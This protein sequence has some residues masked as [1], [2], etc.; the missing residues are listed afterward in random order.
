MSFI[1][2]KQAEEFLDP[3]V[4]IPRYLVGRNSESKFLCENYKI[5]GIVDDRCSPGTLW[6]GTPI[7]KMADVSKDGV[8][9]NA[10]T[11][12]S[13]VAVD[14]ALKKLGLEK[15]LN[16]GHVLRSNNCPP[17]LV[18]WF[19]TDHKMEL[20]SN[21]DYWSMLRSQL[22]D[23][24]SKN[25]LDNIN[26]YRCTADL[27]AMRCYSV[28]Q[29]EQYFEDFLNLRNEVFIDCGGYDGD[30]TEQF[31][32]RCP[33]YKLIKFFEPSPINMAQAKERLKNYRDVEYYQHGLSDRESELSFDLARGS[34]SSINESGEGRIIVRPLD[35]DV[36]EASFIKMDLEG[37]EI[38]AL[39]GSYNL[40]KK[41]RPKLAIAVYHKASHFR[42]VHQFVKSIW[43]DY[44]VRLRHYTQ[45]WSETIMFFF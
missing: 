12:I 42:E 40:I 2:E 14:N 19:V 21:S 27:E 29:D 44:K 33:D 26:L 43:P 38:L 23:Q 16:M 32:R 18:P 20:I 35:R 15:I 45:G 28:R 6:T 1:P 13:P 5:I 7:I 24:T 11:S 4:D 39:R 41:C 22:D 31:S 8:I 10:S 34:A 25:T 37:H 30:T 17:Q 36:K 9:L 3:L